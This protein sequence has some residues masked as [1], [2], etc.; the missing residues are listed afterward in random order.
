MNTPSFLAIIPARGGSKRL[1]GKNIRPLAGRPL[2]A[3]SILTA[4]ACSYISRVI[5]SSDDPK[6]LVTTAQWNGDPV[7]RPPALSNDHASTLSAMQHV[8]QVVRDSGDDPSH[9]ALFQCTCPLR[10]V[11]DVE[12]AIHRYLESGA[13]SAL[14]VTEIHLKA[15][16]LNSDG[17]YVPQYQ[18]GV[19]KQDLEPLYQENGA[20][21]LTRSDLVDQGTLLGPRTLI[22]NLPPEAGIASIDY[23]F[24]FQLTEALYHQ[25][26]Y[27]AEFAPLAKQQAAA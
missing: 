5:V 17:W 7:R 8:L 1:P 10:R 12:K 24:D 21:Y 19:R 25:L 2:L 18:V 26:N 9:I 23:E 4:R 11:I 27:E 6:I 3:Y 22:L 20:L 15:G 13:D 16:K 14:S